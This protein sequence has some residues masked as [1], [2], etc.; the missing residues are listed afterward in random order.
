MLALKK[1]H[2]ANSPIKMRSAEQKEVQKN[3]N[4]SIEYLLN[5]FQNRNELGY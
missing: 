3:E 2:L 5:I 1:Y 4:K